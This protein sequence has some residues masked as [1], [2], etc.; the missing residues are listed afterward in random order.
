MVAAGAL[1]TP[2]KRVGPGEL[3]AGTPARF[4]REVTDAERRNMVEA[5]PRYAGLAA[6]YRATGVG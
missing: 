3:W 2:G 5:P 6:E 1:V 4:V